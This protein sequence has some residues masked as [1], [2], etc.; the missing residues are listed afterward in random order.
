L[1]LINHQAPASIL[2][3]QTQAFRIFHIEFEG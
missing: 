3:F 1:E 2:D